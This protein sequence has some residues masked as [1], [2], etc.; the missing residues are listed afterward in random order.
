MCFTTKHGVKDGAVNRMMNTSCL[1]I[2]HAHLQLLV[3]YTPKCYNINYYRRLLYARTII[4]FHL[5]WKLC[6]A[7]V[8]KLQSQNHVVPR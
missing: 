6:N 2:R 8:F 4:G 5:H 7:Y 3:D 1:S